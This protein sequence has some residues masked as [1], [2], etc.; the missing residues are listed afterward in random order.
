MIVITKVKHKADEWISFQDACKTYQCVPRTLQ[1][2]LDEM[3]ISGRYPVEITAKIGRQRIVD[4]LALD[5]YIRNRERLSCGAH[6]DPY[7]P[8]KIAFM[9]GYKEEGIA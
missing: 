2:I 4:R 5:D 6:V 7:D 8:W 1:R 3:K 9:L